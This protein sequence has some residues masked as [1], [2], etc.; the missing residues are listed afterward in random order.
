MEITKRR[1][2]DIVPLKSGNIDGAMNGMSK[3][4][5]RIGV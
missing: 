3:I 2:S 4:L 1:L 5:E